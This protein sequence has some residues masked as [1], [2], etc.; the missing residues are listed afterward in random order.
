MTTYS[1][2]IARRRTVRSCRPAPAAP[3]DDLRIPPTHCRRTSE[4]GGAARLRT[5]GIMA[6][7]AVTKRERV[8][9]L[10]PTYVGD[11]ELNLNCPRKIRKRA[12]C[13]KLGRS[14]DRLRPPNEG[15]L[16]T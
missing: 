10:A 8:I 12:T 13:A 1:V 3:C 9:A 15:A 14:A 4:R 7:I 6:Q 16:S 11:T 2:I 5:H